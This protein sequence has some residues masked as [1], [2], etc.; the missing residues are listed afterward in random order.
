MFRAIAN[1]NLIDA[2]KVER[3]GEQD[4]FKAVRSSE[5]A[6]SNY[7]AINHPQMHGLSVH[8]D[9]APSLD[10]LFHVRESNALTRAV[11]GMNMAVKRLEVSFSPFHIKS[12]IDATMGAVPLTDIAHT[13][14]QV[15]KSFIGRSEGHTGYLTGNTG[16]IQDVLLAGGIKITTPKG[17]VVDEDVN[18]HF[19]DGIDSLGKFMDKVIPGAGKLTKAFI[20]P[21]KIADRVTWE[22]VHAGLKWLVGMNAFERITRTYAKELEK[23]PSAQVPDKWE[24]GRRAASF[25]NDVLGGQNWRRMA[26]DS[27]TRV[28]KLIGTTL[29]SPA[30]RRLAQVLMFAP[31]WTYS[32]VRSFVKGIDSEQIANSLGDINKAQGVGNTLKAVGSALN[33]T[34]LAKGLVNPKT[35]A[36]LHRQYVMRSFLI[37]FT[38][39]NALNMYMSGHPLWDNKGKHGWTEVDLGNGETM[40][41]NKHFNEVPNMIRDPVNFALGKLGVIPS[42][43]IDQALHKEYVSRDYQ[44]DMKESRLTHAAKRLLPFSSQSFNKGNLGSK[45]ANLAGFPIHGSPDADHR[46]QEQQQVY[47][48]AAQ[49]KKDKAAQTRYNHRVLGE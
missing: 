3:L 46:T 13:V 43:L 34:D 2:L 29:A 22:N 15:A 44:P 31:D 42:E 36:D 4:Q 48:D 21:N 10:F 1:K 25:A 38:L 41:A 39:Y 8:S 19:Y 45:L 30:G 27:T 47:D 18:N 24:A 23:D 7:V 20:V 37:Q 26:D 40:Q 9:I 6:P 28:G 5:K 49:A 35:I 32:T 11:E 17:N 12:L 14:G 16:D 33:P